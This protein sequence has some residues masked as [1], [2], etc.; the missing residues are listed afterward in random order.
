MGVGVRR[1]KFL[2]TEILFAKHLPGVLKRKQKNLGGGEKLI[3]PTK[4]FFSKMFL[5]F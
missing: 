1:W 2:V 4:F 5:G 3:F